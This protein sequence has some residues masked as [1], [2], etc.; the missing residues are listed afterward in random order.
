MGAPA[1]VSIRMN[2]DVE[3]DFSPATTCNFR[4]AYCGIPDSLRG[5]GTRVYGTAEQWGD[6]FDSTGKVWLLHI[7][8]G[9]PFTYPGL[10]PLC[11]RL[12]R[13]HYLSINTNLSCR[14]A[15]DFAE[16][17]DPG[18][19]HFINAS[20]HYEE[21]QAVGALG[22]FIARAQML[23]AAR[24]NTLLS[25]V[26]TP[27]M[28]DNFSDISARFERD[29]L[30]LV[31]KMMRGAFEGQRYPGA[32]TPEHRALL[33]DYLAAARSNYAQTLAA[34]GEPPSQ[35]MFSDGRFLEGLDCYHGRLCGS[36]Y[37]FVAV[38]PEGNV[39]RCGTGQPLGNLLRK[40]V[41]L[42]DRPSPC[43]SSYCHY[44]CEKYTSA[45]FAKES[46]ARV[47]P[48]PR[49]RAI[50]RLISRWVARCGGS[51]AQ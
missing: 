43:D 9:E 30:F 4:C 44:F 23:E 10:V 7:T 15:E 39:F 22:A 13:C 6:A 41:K 26:M 37:N 19:V 27:R 2:Y 11:E 48:A 12:A 40:D 36:G 14:S 49:A 32:Y 24:F 51:S 33:R 21:R 35:D 50:R 28:V 20:V 3:A 45:R 1:G 8:G 18:R 5:A 16:R 25:L 42:R 31:P 47:R 46:S 17:I 29:G 34:M 38:T